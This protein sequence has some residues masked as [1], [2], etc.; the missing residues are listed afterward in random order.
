[1]FER[2]TDRARRV[3]ILAQSESRLMN[4]TYIGT[5]HL[6]LGLISEETGVAA[7]A[8]ESLG[9]SLESVRRGVEEQIGPGSTSPTGYIPFT[10]RAKR[11]LEFSLRE[12]LSLG[13]N[14][15]GTEH[16]LLGVLR[17][18]EGRGI[19]VLQTLGADL[20]NLR[21]QVLQ[22][23]PP[24]DP[25]ASDVKGVNRS[26]VRDQVTKLLSIL[27]EPA[28][29]SGDD[30]LRGAELER[31]RA[32]LVELLSTLIPPLPAPPEDDDPN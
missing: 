12:A 25:T 29:F 21:E 24:A 11:T 5:E 23:L 31:V 10:P 22:M 13:N 3:I 32:Q 17:E 14:Y 28:A 4:H 1:M 8:L 18:G 20:T 7:K 30:D 2:F 16:I 15:I 27:G 19:Q 9:A 26:L 6:L